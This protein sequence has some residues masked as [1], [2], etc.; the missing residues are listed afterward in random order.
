MWLDGFETELDIDLSGD[1]EAL[2]DGVLVIRWLFGFTGDA[3]VAGVTEGGC[4][5]CDAE[6]IEDYLETLD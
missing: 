1:T 5:R 2:F 6:F 3:L 4:T